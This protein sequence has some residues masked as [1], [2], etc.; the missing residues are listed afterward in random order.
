MSTQA[1]KLAASQAT[2]RRENTMKLTI[3]VYTL[4]FTHQLHAEVNTWKR[5]VE[6][7]LIL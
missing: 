3:E 5:A 2:K 7:S 6:K 4:P 1:H